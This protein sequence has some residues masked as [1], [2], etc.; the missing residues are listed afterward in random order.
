VEVE[1]GE[2]R[3]Q[4]PAG[5]VADAHLFVDEGDPASELV[6]ERHH[7]V[8]HRAAHPRDA[9][10]GVEKSRSIGRFPSTWSNET[11]SI[12]SGGIRVVRSLTSPCTEA[13]P[14]V[15]IAGG[16]WPT[17][18]GGEDAATAIWLE[19]PISPWAVR[20]RTRIA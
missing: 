2:R 19:D 3:P 4:A 17:P 14:S 10:R 13:S 6:R 15:A 12:S 18:R 5:V 11:A 20:V 1:C 8:G 16:R 7:D 9:Q